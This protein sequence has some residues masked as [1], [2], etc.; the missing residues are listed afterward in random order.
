[1]T[2]NESTTENKWQD[3][4]DTHRGTSVHTP[5][6]PDAFERT[7]EEKMELISQ[8]FRDIMTILGLDLTDD[9]LAGTPDRVAKMYVKEVFAGLNPTNKPDVKLFD[10]TYAY[11]DMLLEKNITVHSHC[12]HH[13]VPIIGKCHVA[14]IPKDKVVGLS[15]LNRIVRHYAKRPQVQERLTQQIANALEEALETPDVA[16]YMEADHMCVL[17]RG[18]EDHGSSTVTQSLRGAFQEGAKRS[19]FFNAI[20]S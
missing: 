7:D 16:V 19:E 14:Y 11:E 20:R 5:L 17:T 13:F 4:I 2:R 3:L 12:E 15:K 8:K 9:S 6:R 10:N 18:I 1:M